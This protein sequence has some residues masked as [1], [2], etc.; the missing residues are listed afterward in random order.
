[1]KLLLLTSSLIRILLYMLNELLYD[2]NFIM[3]F[4]LYINLLL[5]LYTVNMHN[6]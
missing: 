5:N 4:I 2:D 1:M 6:K 3:Q